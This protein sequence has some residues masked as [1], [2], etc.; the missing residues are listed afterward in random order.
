MVFWEY[1]FVD[2]EN[3]F[4]PNIHFYKNLTFAYMQLCAKEMQELDA[5]TL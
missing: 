3:C 4:E 1:V 5:Y 2:L